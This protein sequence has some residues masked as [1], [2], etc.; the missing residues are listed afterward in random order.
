MIKNSSVLSAIFKRDIRRYFSNPSGYVF[1]TLFIFLS[2]AAAFWQRG[3]FLAN[4]ANLDQLN[5]LF[6]LILVFFIP[7]LTMPIWAEE[8]R[9]GTEELLLS[10]PASRLDIVLGKYLAALGIYTVS[11]A[12]SMSHIIIL[13]I[14]GKPDLGLMIGNYFGYWILGAALIPIGMVA[15]QFTKNNTVSFIL[16]VLLIGAITFLPTLFSPLGKDVAKLVSLLS[17]KH[18]FD[19]LSSGIISISTVT[20]FIS[21]FT[22]GIY[23]NILF[24]KRNEWDVMSDNLKLSNHLIIRFISLFLGL[25]ALNV[26]V[27]THIPFR[28]DVT[29]EKLHSLSKESIAFL[30]KLPKDKP[31]T[32]QAYFSSSVPSE[33]AQVHSNLVGFLREIN[34]VAGPKVTVNIVNTKEFSKS[35]EEAR[36]KYNITPQNVTVLDGT[37]QQK[38]LFLGLAITCGTNEQVIP[39]FDKGLPVEYELMR[40][41]KVVSTDKKKTIGVIT[42]GLNINGGYDYQTKK[43]I[44]QWEAIKELKKQYNVVTISPKKP[45]SAAV[46]AVL[47]PLPSTLT[48]E[49]LDNV[50]Q[51]ILSGVPAFIMVDPFPAEAPNLAPSVDPNAQRNMFGQ[52]P[53]PTSPQKGDIEAFLQELGVKWDKSEIVW[54][55]YNPHPTLNLTLPEIV[56]ID[57]NSKISGFNKGNKLSSG[58][59]EMVFIFGGSL[60]PADTANFAF[61]PL[62]KTTVNSGENKYDYY[63]KRSFFGEQFIPQAAPHI[64]DNKRYIMMAEVSGA[65]QVDSSI[66]VPIHAIVAADVDFISQQFFDIRNS[67]SSLNFDNI[68]I[69]LN[70]VD[71]LVGDTTLVSLRKKRAK[72][73]TLERVDKMKA[74]FVDK[75]LEEKKLAEQEAQKALKEANNRLQQKINEVKNRDGIDEQTKEIMLRNAQEIEQRRFDAQKKKIDARKKLKI[76]ESE[77]ELAANIKT[78]QNRIKLFAVILPPIPVLLFGLYIFFKRRKKEIEGTITARR[79]KE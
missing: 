79:V 51:Y 57:N 27:S 41:I 63:L 30:K 37:V 62:V 65:T 10:L 36:K 26:I 29:E 66:T 46:D 13:M 25:I 1:I 16:G 54:D 7:S 14:L 77:A 60:L 68:S 35:A 73:R 52:A 24:I 4:L 58:L 23:F 11:I 48:Q 22:L 59:Q 50:K 21:L 44:P 67:G 78:I 69:F 55:R 64:P 33:Y 74:S 28:I 39:F 47:L 49:E 9:S 72:L 42:T 31:I 3:F 71:L 70:A 76:K 12:I 17:V 43:Q 32:I 5:Y 61:S 15:S 20:Y 53:Q 6:P 75:Q 8:K 18:Y 34:A 2:A 40:T 19:E 56:F 38:P 45:I